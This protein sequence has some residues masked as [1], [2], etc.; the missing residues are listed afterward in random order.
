MLRQHTN[1][2]SAFRSFLLFGVGASMV[3]FSDA[4]R[5]VLAH[6]QRLQAASVPLGEAVGLALAEDVASDVDMPPFDKS[7]MDGFAV[8][9][10]DLHAAP[11]VLRVVEE[12]PAGAVPTR[13]VHPGECSRIMTGA[14][15]PSGADAVVRVE[16]TKPGPADGETTVVKPIEAGG[17]I[18]FR[19]EDVARGDVVLR[20]GHVIRPPEV[21]LL[22]SCGCARVPVFRRPRVAMLSTGNEVVPVDRVPAPGQIRDANGPYLAARLRALGVEAA[23][24]GIAPDEPSRLRAALAEGMQYDALVV[25]GGV[26]RGDYDFVPAILRELGTE[27]IFESVAMQPGRPTVFGVCGRTVVFALPGNPV[28]LM[29]TSELFLVPALR[30]MLGYREVNPRRR[31][32][33]LAEPVHH[34]PGRLAYVPGILS[35]TESG[36]TVRPLPYHGSAHVA[37]LSQ[38]DC[39]VVLPAEVAAVEAGSPVEVVMMTGDRSV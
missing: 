36:W 14:P 15:V 30:T 10:A 20:A 1:V 21:A 13:A 4:L 24:L 26:S 32:A 29:V 11:R 37:A 31:K 23:S 5:T 16:D 35:E 6:V 19:A 34:R 3:D 12:I 17:N 9:A 33:I 38:S 7:A 18:C 27:L 8:V 25:S 39:L 2:M 22:G 28:S